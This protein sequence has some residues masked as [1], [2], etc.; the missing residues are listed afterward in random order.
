MWRDWSGM[1]RRWP[2]QQQRKP[3][4]MWLILRSR[5]APESLVGVIAAGGYYYCVLRRALLCLVDLRVLGPM[6]VRPWGRPVLTPR[7]V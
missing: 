6:C 1:R 3:P 4:M 2:R 5:V 7:A